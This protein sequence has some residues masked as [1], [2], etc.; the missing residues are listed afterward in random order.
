MSLKDFDKLCMEIG[1]VYYR[2]KEIALNKHA[3]LEST[4]NTQSETLVSVSRWTEWL[5]VPVA[6]WGDVVVSTDSPRNEETA[7]TGVGDTNPKVMMTAQVV[8]RWD[9]KMSYYGKDPVLN[10]KF[11]KINCCAG[12]CKAMA[13]MQWNK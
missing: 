11:T 9:A 1:A 6:C 12:R 2:A 4:A 3:I 10:R 7:D 5:Y 13:K 8:S